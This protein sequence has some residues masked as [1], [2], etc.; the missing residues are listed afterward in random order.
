NMPD[1]QRKIINERSPMTAK[2][3]GKPF[4]I[5]TRLDWDNIRIDIMYWCLRVKLA[6][7]FVSFGQILESTFNKQ[8]VEDSN[9]D[10]FWGAI[11]YVIL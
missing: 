7:N 6:Q 2:M 1:V 11:K 3:V 10:P 8:I 4:R 5:D 9:K